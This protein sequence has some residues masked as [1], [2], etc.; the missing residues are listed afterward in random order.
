MLTSCQF[1]NEPNLEGAFSRIVGFA[2]KSFPVCR[3]GGGGG[4]GGGVLGATFSPFSHSPAPT[5][6]PPPPS[7][8]NIFNQPLACDHAISLYLCNLFS[9]GGHDHIQKSQNL[10]LFLI[11]LET[12]RMICPV[13]IGQNVAIR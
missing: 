13:A 4:G 12:I 8:H 9:G 10:D 3:G 1:T 2:G 6:P 11:G 7:H 5:P